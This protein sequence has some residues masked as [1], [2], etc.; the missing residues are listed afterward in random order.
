MFRLG[1]S[2]MGGKVIDDKLFYD[3]ARCGISAMEI[4]IREDMKLDYKLV[5]DAS[6]KYGV[7]VATYHLPFVNYDLSNPE[8]ADM[9]ME[10][11]KAIINEGTS[12][13]INTYIIHPCF[14]VTEEDRSTR[15]ALAK[16]NLPIMAE[17]A[18]RLG[19]T[20]AVENLPNQCIGRTSD[21]ILEFIGTH[22]ALRA[23]FDM[24]HLFHE[25]QADF[26]RKIGDKL[27]T[28]HISDYDFIFERHWMPGEGKID[29]QSVIAALKEI[30]YQ[31][32]WMYEVSYKTPKTIFRDR[33][34][35]AEDFE[36]N[37]KELFAGKAPTVI[38][39]PNPEIYK[40]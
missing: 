23:C 38:G 32:I 2:T 33:E 35:T 34:F 15:F 5:R 28:T 3:Y 24:N 11:F 18:Q 14:E 29:W 4:S 20:L 12:Y 31:G 26:I 16:K 21:E 39:T 37:A 1:L 10:H 36:R 8:I 7:E 22:P 25:T 9:S 6:E 30:N 19:A 17:Y 40:K 27:L 13:G